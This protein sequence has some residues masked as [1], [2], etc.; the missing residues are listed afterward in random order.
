MHFRAREQKTPEEILRW[1]SEK[2]YLMH[3]Y[4]NNKLEYEEV[5]A[6]SDHRRREGQAP[7]DNGLQTWMRKTDN[8]MRRTA[9]QLG[10]TDPRNLFRR[11]A[12]IS[13]AA[14]TNGVATRPENIH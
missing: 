10:R 1:F 8:R 11:R 4:D 7:P 14:A 3:L 6:M 13:S 5:K 9:D 2:F 12:Q